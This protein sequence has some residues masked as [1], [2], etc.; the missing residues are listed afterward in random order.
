MKNRFL[1]LGLVTIMAFM[2]M[3][4]C[5]SKVDTPDWMISE[6]TIQENETVTIEEEKSASVLQ[7]P[8]TPA[9]SAYRNL[10]EQ[11]TFDWGEHEWFY[12]TSDFQFSLINSENEANTT[13]L[14]LQNKNSTAAAGTQHLLIYHAGEMKTLWGYDQNCIYIQGFAK[15]KETKEQFY[16]IASGGRQ[17]ASYFY[18]FQLDEDNLNL[19]AEENIFP[20]RSL[21]EGNYECF[22]YWQG[23][24]VEKTEYLDRYDELLDEEIIGITWRDNTE[25]NRN[26]IF[27]K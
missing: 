18:V 14:L 15:D 22:Y 23:N 27:G 7:Y 3:A 4:G 9:T 6:G 16:F 12:N 25:E 11:E 10:L 2:Y 26:F 13:Y 5:T 8:V 17:D 21:E 20:D 24:E 1:S 19:I